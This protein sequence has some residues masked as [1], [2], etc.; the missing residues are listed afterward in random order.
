[1]SEPITYIADLV[2]ILQKI[3]RTFV[4][5]HLQNRADI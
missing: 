1:M 5:E 2:R 4:D 3:H